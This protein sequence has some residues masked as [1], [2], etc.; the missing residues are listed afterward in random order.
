MGLHVDI[1]LP[2]VGPH[3]FSVSQKLITMGLAV[4]TRGRK[5]EV[6]SIPPPALPAVGAEVQVQV[7]TAYSPHNFYVQ[8][9]SGEMVVHV[10]IVFR[11]GV[12]SMLLCYG[13]RF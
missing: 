10:D 7:S 12:C 5:R 8:M 3:L 13:I 11:D 1:L 2:S 9:V 4:R 6:A